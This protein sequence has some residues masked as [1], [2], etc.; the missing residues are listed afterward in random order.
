MAS[1]PLL[2]IQELLPRLHRHITTA[3]GPADASLMGGKMGYVLFEAYYNQHFGI[4]DDSLLWAYISDSLN[5]VQEGQMVHSFASGISGVAW[6]FLHLHNQGLL[7]DDDLDAQGIVEGLDEGLFEIS[8]ALLQG[9]DFDYLHGGLS[10]CLYFLERTPSPQIASYV[11]RMVAQLAAVAVR[12]DDGSLSW[13]F[14]DFGRLALATS[15]HYNLGLS[16]GT[17][18]IV[19]IL[20]LF[21][22]RGYAPEQCK[23]LIIGNLAWLWRVRNQSCVSVFPNTVGEAPQ[24]QESRLAWCY[25][26]L[27]IANAFW[28]AGEKLHQQPWKDI[29][30]QTVR[31]AATRHDVETRVNDAPLCHGAFGV[32]Y[33]FQ[34]F[35]ERLQDDLLTAAADTWVQKGLGYTLPNDEGD[36]FLS[37]QGTEGGYAS[38]LSVL[39]GE[40][41][42]GL[43]FL[44][45]LGASKAWDRFLLIS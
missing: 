8:M 35:A 43:A 27:G 34:R 29:A 14:L 30:A 25:G 42:I 4:T 26:D 6:A 18:S 23:E 12:F 19:S 16:H 37:Y 7:Q 21:Y 40:A 20:S 9:G 22:E 15:E 32:A 17:A 36:V 31:R 1:T 2:T 10:A 39:D 13:K 3:S 38:N 5:A 33:L 45:A 11:E 24:D 41:G 28:L 44:S